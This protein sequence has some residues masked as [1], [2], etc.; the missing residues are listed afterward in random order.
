MISIKKVSVTNPQFVGLVKLLDDELTI[1]DGEDHDFYDQYNQLD[2]IKNAVVL[3][4]DKV[5]LG[6]GAIKHFDE[7]RMEVKRMYVREE[8]RGKGYATQILSYLERWAKDLGY[9]KCVLE[10]GIRQPEAIAFYKKCQYNIIPNYGQYEGVEN[11]V[12]F[13]KEI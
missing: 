7:G 12:C 5:A 13:E 2:S 8:D 11:S 4:D 1:R 10:T 3:Y 9:Q 6:C